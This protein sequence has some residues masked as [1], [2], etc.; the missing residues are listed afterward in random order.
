MIESELGRKLGKIQVQ[1]IVETKM[2]KLKKM[3]IIKFRYPY[4][5]KVF[6]LRRIK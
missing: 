6:S 2:K 4:C 3:E 1:N 5:K